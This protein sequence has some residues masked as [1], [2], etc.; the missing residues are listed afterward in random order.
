MSQ[1]LSRRQFIVMS[2]LSLGALALPGCN[3]A[4]AQPSATVAATVAKSSGPQK[5]GTLRIGFPASPPTLDP[6]GWPG[7][8]LF[9]TV[10]DTLTQNDAN[11]IPQ[12]SLATSWEASADGLQWTFKLRNEVKF[13]HGTPFTAKDVVYT[14]ERLLDPKNAYPTAASFA[15]VD[16]VVAVD[17]NTVQ[18]KL[19]SANVDFPLLL[20]DPFSGAFIVPHDRTTEQLTQATSGTGAYILKEYKMSEYSHLVRNPDYWRE[21]SG[22]FDEIRHLYIADIATRVASLNSNE[23]DVIFKLSSSVMS[24]VN[25]EVAEVVS[26]IS[27]GAD[28]IVMSLAAE[29]FTDVRVR[30]AMKYLVD[31]QAMLQIVLQGQGV[32]GN[33]QHLSP[34]HPFA[35]DLPPYPHDVAKAKALLTEAGYPD[36]FEVKMATSQL[37]A[38]MESAA[39]AFQEM[40]KAAGVKIELV[41]IPADNYWTEYFNYP[42]FMSQSTSMPSTDFLFTAAFYSTSA[43]NESAFKNPTADKLID[44]AR[45]EPDIA[46][47]K[48]MYG[49]LQKI[50]QDEG[51]YIIS[52]F[53]PVLYAQRKGI[54]GLVFTPNLMIYPHAG[55]FTQG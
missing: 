35:A 47:R 14:F 11:F 51:G 44:A 37:T 9:V 36:G 54:E 53:N 4:P 52:Y 42:M 43:W 39:V 6:P 25:K 13:H 41:N 20:G 32:I 46:K 12:P 16:K 49:Q 34:G 21:N 48:E 17:D 45:I 7:D 19:K 10:Y 18:F 33:D 30:Q 3:S 50:I 15:F 40:A 28:P 2:T 38:S 5:G 55:Y 31:R 29:P 22:Y 23:L 1:K 26:V 27:G 24:T 8:N